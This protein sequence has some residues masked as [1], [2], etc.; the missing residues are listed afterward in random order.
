MT[1]GP[2]TES[3][4][5]FGGTFDYKFSPNDR[6]S[7]SIH[8]VNFGA[9][10]HNHTL[11][12]F[13]NRVLP[14][15]FTLTSTRGFA[16]AGEVRLSN[17]ERYRAGSSLSPS[18]TYRHSGPVWK[19]EAGLGY[20][21]A[22][23]NFEDLNRGFFNSSVA[24][25][26]GVTVS[27]D[28]ITYLRPGTITVTDPA[29]NAP[30]DY[31]NIGTYSLSTA[32]STASESI[33]VQ[34]TA[35]ANLA[36]DFTWKI[37]FSLKGGLDVR[38]SLRDLR[39]LN[40]PYNFVGA[41]GRASLTPIG[42]DDSASVVLDEI[43]SRRFPG[44]GFPRVQWVDNAALA[45]LSLVQPSYLTAD[46]NGAYR[47]SVN[48]SKHAEEIISSIYL[49][50]DVQCLDRRLKVTA[51]IRAEQTN[52]KAEGPLT[53]P[54]RN[55]QRDANG[56]LV[57]A[58]NGQP[59]AISAVP[60]EVAQR[61]IIDRGLRSEKEY[62]RL[63]PSLNVSYNLRENLIARGAHYWS[64]GRPDFNQYAGGLTLPAN[65]EAAPSAT[66]RIS[67]NNAAI[68]AWSA[69]TTKLTLE[70]YFEGVGLFSVAGFPPRFREFLRQHRLQRDPCLPCPLRPRP[71]DLRPFR[72]RDDAEHPEH[73]P[74][75]RL[76][77]QLQ[78]GADVPPC[79]GPRRAGLCQRQH[80]SR[81]GR[82]LRELCRL[83]PAHRQLGRQPHPPAVQCE[84]QLELPQPAAPGQ[85]RRW[86][87]HR[88]RHLQLEFLTP[89]PQ[90][91]RRSPVPPALVVV[92]QPAQSHRRPRGRRNHEPQHAD[93]RPTP[94]PRR[95]RLALVDRREDQV[96]TAA[97]TLEPNPTV[98]VSRRRGAL[99][100]RI[101]DYVR[102][103]PAG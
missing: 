90:R 77:L 20:S 41:D 18:L 22:N 58:A 91:R 76:R 93:S 70:Y 46:Q 45:N 68:K 16:G 57:L 55:F 47:N 78:A 66:N 1:H 30:V 42:N 99:T 15:D 54:T 12:F 7:F 97:P 43:F 31:T 11:G 72:C 39:G 3:R 53:D 83:R 103:N 19:A 65:I 14:G 4:A 6:L 64:V 69:G 79:V 17:N 59:V 38:H 49:R 94:Q 62:L 40:S 10:F 48:L 100:P 82:R 80:P 63:F 37:P 74:N 88:S 73:G 35:F 21:E 75:G 98:G 25:R 5:S 86:P 102:S 26:T 87:Q 23:T 89:L 33:D 29:T 28:N 84:I 13:V 24:R 92:R 44:F 34:R 52:V 32:G 56:R 36:R 50:G 95:L 51:G 67:V 96:L 60:L 71:G 27:F 101:P 85:G 2:R 8:R 81:D 9:E 61:T